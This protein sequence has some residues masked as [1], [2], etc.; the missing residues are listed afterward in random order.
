MIE[1]LD[2]SIQEPLKPHSYPIPF[3]YFSDLTYV[4]HY[5]FWCCFLASI[6]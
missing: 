3:V 5:L 6:S 4:W 1:A 2:N